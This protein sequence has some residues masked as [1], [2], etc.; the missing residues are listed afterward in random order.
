M[1]FPSAS[2]RK[3][4]DYLLSKSDGMARKI[5]F[6]WLMK[7]VTMICWELGCNKTLAN[8]ISQGSDRQSFYSSR[9]WTISPVRCI[10]LVLDSVILVPS[11]F[12][13]ACINIRFCHEKKSFINEH[14]NKFVAIDMSCKME[15][16]G[17]QWVCA[18]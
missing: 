1:V 17:P 11:S 12:L 13:Y 3:A 2:W 4:I 6:L 9:T 8:V 16:I 18:K 7:I 10:D 5:R 14:G 15:W